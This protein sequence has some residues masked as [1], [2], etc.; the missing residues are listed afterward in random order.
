MV[1]GPSSRKRNVP[2]QNRGAAPTPRYGGMGD[3]EDVAW[4]PST[5]YGFPWYAVPSTTREREQPAMGRIPY[6]LQPGV[7]RNPRRE[8]IERDRKEKKEWKW[9]MA[10]A[11]CS[12][13]PRYDKITA[14]P[15]HKVQEGRRVLG[16]MR[17]GDEKR[18][19]EVLTSEDEV[20][21]RCVKK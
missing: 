12:L 8:D 1:C 6:K 17:E 11:E 2:R 13:S 4:P 20:Y 16:A 10:C 14:V 5:L 18:K 9:T 21:I 7:Y 15:P 19:R 3:I